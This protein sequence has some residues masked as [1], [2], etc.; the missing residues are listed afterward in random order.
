[1]VE[2]HRAATYCRQR[3]ASPWARGPGAATSKQPLRLRVLGGRIWG[4]TLSPDWGRS[5]RHRDLQHHWMVHD[6]G[7]GHFRASNS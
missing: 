4:A 2:M 1:M 3:C 7:A 5:A 6:K